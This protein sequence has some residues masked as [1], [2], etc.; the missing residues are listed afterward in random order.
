[1]VSLVLGFF[2][3]FIQLIICVNKSSEDPNYVS[4]VDHIDNQ[5]KDKNYEI[6]KYL[7]PF[8]NSM[9]LSGR[10]VSAYAFQY[11]YFQVI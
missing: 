8:E 7:T 11:Y 1:M 9:I 10:F 5:V 3:L 2:I 6:D 4:L